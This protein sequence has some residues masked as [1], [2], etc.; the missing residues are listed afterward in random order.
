MTRLL[1]DTAP[2]QASY[3]VDINETKCCLAQI[4]YRLNYSHHNNHRPVALELTTQMTPMKLTM[5][6]QVCRLIAGACAASL[7]MSA[8]S[9]A[10][11][12]E[13]PYI[14]SIYD[15]GSWD[16]GLEP[17]AGGPVAVPNN[18]VGNRVSSVQFRPNDNSTYSPGNRIVSNLIM[19]TPIPTPAGP[20]SINTNGPDVPPPAGG[21]NV[22][23]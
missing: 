20:P 8:T 1:R 3:V 18:A 16:I 17:A 5:Y 6:K 15:W 14:D 12:S 4:M 11:S 10:A 2:V 9:H 19:P 7:L 13:Q 21:P 22:G 23:F